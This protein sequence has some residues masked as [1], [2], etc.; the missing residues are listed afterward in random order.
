MAEGWQLYTGNKL[1]QISAGDVIWAPGNEPIGFKATGIPNH[2]F[3]YDILAFEDILK[4]REPFA[5]EDAWS[6]N[7]NYNETICVSHSVKWAF[8]FFG[9]QPFILEDGMHLDIDCNR[10]YRLIKSEPNLPMTEFSALLKYRSIEVVDSEWGE[11]N[12]GVIGA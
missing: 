6:V 1:N 9:E 11:K 8:Q 10:R 5:P 12:L 4:R 7:L 2:C 3:M